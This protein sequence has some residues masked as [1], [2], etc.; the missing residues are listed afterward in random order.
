[1]SRFSDLIIVNSYAGKDYYIANGYCG[2]RMM[3]IPNGID[4][5]HFQPNEES[6]QR[7]RDEWGVTDEQVLIGHVGRLDPMKD[8]A[9]FLQTAFLLVRERDDVRFVCIGG[10]PE[11]YRRTLHNIAEGFE[12]TERLKWIGARQDMCAVYNALDILTSSSYG[13]GFP[14]VIGE[15]M[16]CGTPCVVTGVGDSARIVEDTGIVVPP[17]VPDALYQAWKKLL[18]LSKEEREARGQEARERICAE[19]SLRHLIERTERALGGLLGAA[20][21]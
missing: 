17:K 10:G 9:N 15:A 2:K 18:S 4:T 12:L 11:P 14:N 19:F 5:E 20:S 1:M 6:G 21:K 16:S 13:E 8:H 7:V 3:V